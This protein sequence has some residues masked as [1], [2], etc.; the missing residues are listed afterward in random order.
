MPAISAAQWISVLEQPVCAQSVINKPNSKMKVR[1][2]FPHLDQESTVY[3]A[4]FPLS[5]PID[6]GIRGVVVKLT[7]CHS[8]N[9]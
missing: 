4:L 6:K 2:G 1:F 7:H 3:C 9:K 5:L 8:E